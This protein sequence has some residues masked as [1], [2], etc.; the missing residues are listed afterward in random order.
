MTAELTVVGERW[1]LRARRRLKPRPPTH[2][3]RP[4]PPAPPSR[5]RPLPPRP[6]PLR[7][8]RPRPAH[9]PLLPRPSQ[10][11]LLSLR[12]L[13][14]RPHSPAP[15]PQGSS[16]PALTG[17]APAEPPGPRRTLGPRRPSAFCLKGLS[18]WN[19]TVCHAPRPAASAGGSVIGEGGWGCGPTSRTRAALGSAQGG[20]RT[21]GGVLAAN[22]EV[23][24]RG[25]FAHRSIGH[26]V[27]GGAGVVQVLQDWGASLQ[28]WQEASSGPGSSPQAPPP[29][30]P[31][32]TRLAPPLTQLLPVAGAGPPG[33]PEGDHVRPAALWDLLHRRGPHLPAGPGARA[34]PSSPGP[35]RGQ[36]RSTPSRRPAAA[37]TPAPPR[38][39]PSLRPRSYWM[40]NNDSRLSGPWV[41][42]LPPF[43]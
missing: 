10:L 20:A 43:M 17:P 14:L 16:R 15:F 29:A 32:Q 40:G 2:R 12:P 18:L 31:P 28:P 35:A 4:Q 5:S 39:A 30:P 33:L 13:P 38:P 37:A 27:R 23:G 9:R 1:P 3:P 36:P 34:P 11:R 26:L 21:S 42:C 41:Q 8:H 7:P 25:G 6:L 19:H 22:A 24:V